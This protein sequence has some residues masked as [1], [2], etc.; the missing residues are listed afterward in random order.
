[1]GQIT[2]IDNSEIQV[3]LT[4]QGDTF[5]PD[6][7]YQQVTNFLG[8]HNKSSTGMTVRV[9]L[10]VSAGQQAYRII[11][12]STYMSE[13]V[14]RQDLAPGQSLSLPVPMLYGTSAPAGTS[15]QATFGFKVSYVQALDVPEDYDDH[16]SGVI[17]H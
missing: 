14:V 7:N 13:A 11:F 10:R 5:I 6:Q 1:M 16:E 3:T 12:Q 15:T 4:A 9:G 17:R 8:L 2:A